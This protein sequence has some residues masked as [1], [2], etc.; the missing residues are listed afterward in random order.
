[1]SLSVD[2]P[3]E[4]KSKRC[5]LYVIGN[6]FDCNRKS[7]VIEDLL[8][9]FLDVQTIGDRNLRKLAFSH[10]VQTTRKTSVTDPRHKGLQ[11]IVISMLEISFLPP[12]FVMLS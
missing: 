7:L 11:K 4:S 9:L 8:A 12:D 6:E 5:V 10:I 1:M 2:S 3:Y